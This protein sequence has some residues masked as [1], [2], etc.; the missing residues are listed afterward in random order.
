M[1]GIDVSYN[2]NIRLGNASQISYLAGMIRAEFG[3]NNLVLRVSAKQRQRQAYIVIEIL[4]RLNNPEAPAQSVISNLACRCLAYRAGYSDYLE[5][6]LPAVFPGE[7]TKGS[8]GIANLDYA[9]VGK[10][11]VVESFL[12][13]GT[14]GP[15]GKGVSYVI[16]AVE[17]LP[18][19]G[20]EAI[21]SLGS[22]GVRTNAGETR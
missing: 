17:V 13:H 10:F 12:D 14:N 6:G 21:A 18:C 16:M 4:R 7:I 8:Y 22:P 1:G 5:A 11:G 9:F 20:K 19:D 2:R 3:D 15:L